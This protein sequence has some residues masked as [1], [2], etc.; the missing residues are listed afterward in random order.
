MTNHHD[1][2]QTGNWP[3][4]TYRCTTCGELHQYKRAYDDIPLTSPC[5]DAP[6]IRAYNLDLGDMRFYTTTLIKDVRH[7]L[8]REEREGK[9]PR[10]I[11]RDMNPH[12]AT[13]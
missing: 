11:D 6:K 10:A 13:V 12:F 7:V 9:R 5:C 3:V 1:A 2:E 4:R 8:R